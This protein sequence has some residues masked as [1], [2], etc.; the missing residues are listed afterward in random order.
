MGA[1]LLAI[2]LF[3]LGLALLGIEIFLL[4]GFGVAGVSG[5]LLVLAGLVLAGLDKAP[6]AR[7]TGSHW[8]QNASLRIDD[9]RGRRVSVHTF[10]L[11]KIRM[12]IG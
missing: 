11:P 8:S 1:D 2:M 9:G 10:A 4:P 3:L 7:R 5:I 6:E 12:R